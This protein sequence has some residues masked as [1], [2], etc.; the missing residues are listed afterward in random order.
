M[1]F[2]VAVR[3]C[4][5][6]KLNTMAD[7]SSDSAPSRFEVR[8]T[9]E[10][11]FSWLRT[12]MSLERTLMSWVRTAISLIGFGFTIVQFFDRLQQLPGIKPALFPDAAWYLGL[13]L[14]FCGVLALIIAIKQYQWGLRY[15][16]SENFSALAGATK[17]GMQSS[18]LA[19]AIVLAAIGTI[20]F[21]TVLLRLV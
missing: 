3:C 18:A 10:S 14:I 5:Q 12:R 19:V 15:L 9:A 17:M 1:A 2:V 11:H 16:W 8:T 20:A 13:A 4:R 21:V 7:T 6:G